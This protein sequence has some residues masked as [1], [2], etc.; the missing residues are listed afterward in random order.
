[1]K[2]KLDCPNAK[3]DNKMKVW[4]KVVDNYCAYQYFKSCKGWWVNTEQAKDCLMREKAE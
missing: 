4:C 2:I 1:M 3:H